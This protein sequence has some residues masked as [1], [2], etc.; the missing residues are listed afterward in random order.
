MRTSCIASIAHVGLLLVVFVHLTVGN[1]VTVM[2]YTVCNTTIT[3][4]C[5]LDEL[6]Y[7]DINSIHVKWLFYTMDDT[8]SNI[9]NGSFI[10]FDF[11]KNLSGN[12]TCEAYSDLN[13]VKNVIA[14]NLVHQWFSREE[15]QFILSLL[16]IYIILLW[17]NVYT[18]TSKTSNISKLIHV[19]SIALWM[20]IIMFVGQYMIG[21][22]TDMIYVKINGIILIQLSIISSVFLQR[23]LHKTIIP[24]YL[25]NIVMGLKVLSFT[26]STIVIALSFVGCYNKAYGYTYVYKLLFAD[27]LELISL[28]T[29]YVLPFGTQTTYKRLYLQSDETF[30]FP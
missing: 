26:G 3:L 12:Y 9:T 23:I 10:K 21:I 19:Y 28:I 18:I 5:N 4:E 6:I 29:L 1:K 2:P 16:T 13:S 20:T 27:V 7:K 14:L 22:N 11:A 8:I 17:C 25:L 24:S 15:L 30:T